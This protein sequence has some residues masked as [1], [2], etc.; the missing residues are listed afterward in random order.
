VG[1]GRDWEMVLVGRCRSGFVQVFDKL[2]ICGPC[3]EGEELVSEN[4][5]CIY[6]RRD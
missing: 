2:C 3:L 5:L 1:D 4:R 6:L